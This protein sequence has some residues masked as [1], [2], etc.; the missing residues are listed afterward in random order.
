MLDW[1][2]IL[3]TEVAHRDHHYQLV[4]ISAAF[5]LSKQL[6]GGGK[7]AERSKSSDP[8]PGLRSPQFESRGGSRLLLIICLLY[9]IYIPLSRREEVYARPKDSA[10]ACRHA[11]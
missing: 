3:G 5:K 4:P 2:Q 7:V 10:E 6:L 11:P 8:L 9:S 1:N